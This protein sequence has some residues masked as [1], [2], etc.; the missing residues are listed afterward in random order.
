M[1]FN[2]T[3]QLAAIMPMK[4]TATGA[5]LYDEVTKMM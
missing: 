4:G 1:E 5:D 2:V 3:E